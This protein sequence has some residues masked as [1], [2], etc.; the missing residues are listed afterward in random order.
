M[1]YP[2]EAYTT[3]DVLLSILMLPTAFMP[4]A[5]ASIDTLSAKIS[6]SPT[7][8]SPSLPAT[9]ETFLID[10]AH[11]SSSL[12]RQSPSPV[13]VCPF[14]SIT[15][16]LRDESILSIS[17]P[18]SI[19]AIIFAV[20]DAPFSANSMRSFAVAIDSPVTASEISILPPLSSAGVHDAKSTARS[21]GIIIYT[22]FIA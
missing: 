18:S 13:M 3:I 16:C 11:P 17:L 6:P 2:E 15:S 9:S 20:L 8:P 14:P 22:R 1:P 21:I 12:I 10:R 19:S 7:K 5:T 4:C